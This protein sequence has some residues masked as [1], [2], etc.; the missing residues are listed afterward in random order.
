MKQEGVQPRIAWAPVLVGAALGILFS[1]GYLELV[2]PAIPL[3]MIVGLLFCLPKDRRY[4]LRGY[5]PAM[6]VALAV[7]AGAAV[8]PVKKLD[9]PVAALPSPRPSIAE[10]C[11]AGLTYEP[12]SP[13]WNDVRIELSSAAP[14]RNEIIRCINQQ[15][16]LE[17]DV[18][19]CGN[20]ATLL[21]GPW[22]SKIRLRPKRPQ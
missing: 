21:W 5:L 3:T 18:F 16:P 22:T 11:Q 15:T 12:S 6:G 4:R 1:I 8:L 19:G 14:S 9:Q 10:L 17:A 2:I 7:M 20:G 13:D